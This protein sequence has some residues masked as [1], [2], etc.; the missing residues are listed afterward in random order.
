MEGFFLPREI[1]QIYLLE[2]GVTIAAMA[3]CF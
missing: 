3:D 1:V 2:E